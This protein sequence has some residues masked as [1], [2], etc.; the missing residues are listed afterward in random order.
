MVLGHTQ[1]HLVEINFRIV[2]VQ[3]AV[4]FLDE[5][6]VYLFAGCF[7]GDLK[8]QIE[9]LEGYVDVVFHS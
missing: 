5:D 8:L 3:L 1:A 4:D 9:R 7:V 6:A 2:G